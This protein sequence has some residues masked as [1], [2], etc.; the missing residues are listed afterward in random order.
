MIKTKQTVLHN[1]EAG[2]DGNCFSAVLASLLHLRIEMV[3]IFTGPSWRHDVNRWLRKHGLAY[4]Q[5]RDFETACGDFGISGCHHEIG[6]TTTRR[7][8]CL[9]AVVGVDGV[10]VFDPHPDD[11]GLAEIQDCGVFIALEPWRGFVFDRYA[12][13]IIPEKAPVTVS[14]RMTAD[15]RDRLTALGGAKWVR[16]AIDEAQKM[17]KDT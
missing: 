3:P 7:N 14:L 10:P 2:V 16:S 15:Q 13:E 9:H 6:G 8:D 11:T 4:I 12:R 5:L 17:H 1:P